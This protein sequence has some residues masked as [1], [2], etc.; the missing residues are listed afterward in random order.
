[1]CQVAVLLDEE[2]IMDSVMLVEPNHQLNQADLHGATAQ[3][4]AR[5]LLVDRIRGHECVQKQKS[6]LLFVIVTV[7]A[8]AANVFGRS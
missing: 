3:I 8:P 5:R 1:M 6:E 7:D 2:R 4:F